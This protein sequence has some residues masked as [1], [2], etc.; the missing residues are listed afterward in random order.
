M[1][2]EEETKGALLD[3][4]FGLMEGP[5]NAEGIIRFWKNR[6]DLHRVNG[7][8][9][10]I[11]MML[12]H[13][14]EKLRCKAGKVFAEVVQNNQNVQ[15]W[16]LQCSALELVDQYDK[17]SS[18]V[19]KEQVL[20]SLSGTFLF[21]TPVAFARSATP[22]IRLEFLAGKGLDL[23][24]RILSTPE[25]VTRLD[26]KCLSILTNFLQTEQIMFPTAPH[27]VSE[28]VE[29]SGVLRSV[30]Q[31][32]LTAK[33]DDFFFQDKVHTMLEYIKAHK[34]ELIE[35]EAEGIKEFIHKLEE[36]AKSNTKYAE[37]MKESI[38]KFK[39][40]LI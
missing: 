20:S 6:L 3:E 15:K 21:L 34:K 16:A 8:A 27:L 2:N 23:I 5:Q 11:N 32:L 30:V 31:R 22:E 19:L 33:M 14:S 39:A 25:S 18:L 24:L 9:P 7:L 35:K 17:E 37:A 12:H 4:L 13:K 40:I 38:H 28:Q 10:L 36:E 29:K 1:E 26:S